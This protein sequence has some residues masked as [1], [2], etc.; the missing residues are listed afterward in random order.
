MS[1]DVSETNFIINIHCSR[2][3]ECKL[4]CIYTL[5][6]YEDK[7]KNVTSVVLIKEKMKGMGVETYD[8]ED[9]FFLTL[10]SYT[11]FKKN[12]N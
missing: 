1:H 3:N 8:N 4:N 12:F 10:L 5:G 2:L 7:N 9:I 11:M 6:R